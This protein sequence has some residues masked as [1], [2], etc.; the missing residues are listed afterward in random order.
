MN[1]T[2]D[3][4]AKLQLPL[5]RDGFLRDLVR[6]LSG[7]LQDVIGLEEASGFISV[8]GQKM[9]EKINEDYRTALNVSNLNREQVAAVLVDLKQRIHGN[10]SIVSEDNNKIVLQT[11]SC[12]FEDKVIGRPSLCMMTSN[13]FGTITAEN[14][15]YAKVSLEETIASGA[16]GCRV[17]VYLSDN[18]ESAAE[19]GNEYF[20]G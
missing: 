18:D 11:T 1:S 9:G 10:F 12:P 19:E 20:K 13:V 17:V 3:S 6:N 4:L 16:Q 5:E 15:G 7:T 2:Q 8:V 14:L